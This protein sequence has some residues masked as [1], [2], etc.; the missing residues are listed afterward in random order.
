MRS[1]ILKLAA[2]G[3]AALGVI[4]VGGG[5]AANAALVPAVKEA[6][7]DATGGAAKPLFPCPWNPSNNA[8]VTGYV[9]NGHAPEVYYGP[10]PCGDQGFA[11]AP[12]DPVTVHCGVL[13]TDG[14]YWD[15]VTGLPPTP[16]FSGWVADEFLSYPPA[17]QP[18]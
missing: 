14:L 13:A 18:C 1:A 8:N 15:Y 3:A 5:A 6:P 12:G 11:L 10:P 16:P 17:H 7:R 4:G 2:V 9:T